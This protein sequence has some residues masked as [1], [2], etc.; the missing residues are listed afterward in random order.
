MAMNE[1]EL[2]PG[3]PAAFS[4]TGLWSDATNSMIPAHMQAANGNW[5]EIKPVM[6]Y[7]E[8]YE[9]QDANYER[10]GKPGFSAAIMA[11][12]N[13]TG[14]AAFDKIVDEL[15]SDLPRIK[16]QKDKEAIREY[17]VR[18]MELNR[19]LPDDQTP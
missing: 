7:Q 17:I 2:I 1:S 6:H 9:S 12:S 19:K 16:E 10:G 18:A 8:F 3:V 15:N 11:K 4:K 13:P 5:E 14:V